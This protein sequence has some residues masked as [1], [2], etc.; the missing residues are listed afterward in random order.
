MCTKKK[1]KLIAIRCR[2]TIHVAVAISS[3]HEIPQQW[4][5]YREWFSWK[6][7]PMQNMHT[8]IAHPISMKIVQLA[9]ASLHCVVCQFNY[10]YPCSCTWSQDVGKNAMRQAISHNRATCTLWSILAHNFTFP[11][12]MQNYYYLWNVIQ[13]QMNTCAHSFCLFIA[14]NHCILFIHILN[15]M[16]SMWKRDENDHSSIQFLPI[17]C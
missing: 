3:H 1:L 4:Q 5:I 7:S 14:I 9:S 11:Q 12:S 8:H 16:N 6:M 15:F 17:F 13:R 2:L 10:I